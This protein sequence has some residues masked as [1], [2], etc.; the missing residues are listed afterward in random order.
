MADHAR[1]D[2]GS[3]VRLVGMLLAVLV[4]VLFIALN[5]SEV[6]VDVLIATTDV[7][8]AFALLFAALMGFIAGYFA[9]R[10]VR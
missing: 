8:L 10:R 5:F 4:L 7:R 1:R 9:P 2:L 3:Q 6:R